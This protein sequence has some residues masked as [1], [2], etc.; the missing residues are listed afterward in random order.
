MPRIITIRY[1]ASDAGTNL[2]ATCSPKTRRCIFEWVRFEKLMPVPWQHKQREKNKVFGAWKR[3]HA[4]KLTIF[5]F[6]LGRRDQ[7]TYLEIFPISKDNSWLEVPIN[8]RSCNSKYPR[9][10]VHNCERIRTIIASWTHHQDPLLTCFSHLF[11]S[12]LA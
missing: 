12:F 2:A 4:M 7:E 6:W 1:L 5:F 3:N 11:K 8:I 9:C 10:S